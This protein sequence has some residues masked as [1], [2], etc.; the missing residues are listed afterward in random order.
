[1]GVTLLNLIGHD[2]ILTL[3]IRD[4]CLEVEHVMSVGRHTPEQFFELDWKM[5]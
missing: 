3:N 2:G 4:G 5:K 1:M